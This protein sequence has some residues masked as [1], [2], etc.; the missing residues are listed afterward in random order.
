M[1][2]ENLISEY[3]PDE[4]GY[5]IV[6]KIVF[7]EGDLIQPGA[8]ILLVNTQIG[9]YWVVSHCRGIITTPLPLPSDRLGHDETVGFYVQVYIPL[10]DDETEFTFEK[11]LQDNHDLDE[12]AKT[13]RNKINTLWKDAD[14]LAQPEPSEEKPKTDKNTQQTSVMRPKPSLKRSLMHLII[15]ALFGAIV[16]LWMFEDINAPASN[17]WLTGAFFF[18]LVCTFLTSHRWIA[19]I[20]LALVFTAAFFYA[21]QYANFQSLQK[22]IASGSLN[23]LFQEE[24]GTDSSSDA[25]HLIHN[26]DNREMSRTELENAIETSGNEWDDEKGTDQYMVLSILVTN[27]T[28]ALLK[29]L[30]VDPFKTAQWRRLEFSPPLMP[31]EKRMSFIKVQRDDDG[32][33]LETKGRKE[34]DRWLRWS[35]T[36]RYVSVAPFNRK[37]HVA[38]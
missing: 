2:L 27:G 7:Q 11:A 28:N 34:E 16:G 15:M 3:I 22:A 31:H 13:E 35:N 29:S 26:W 25:D 6:E 21:P 5:M 38:K 8:R 17:A 18:G 9:K 1:I 33:P 20:S 10:S 12:I 24:I 30:K 36:H 37:N 4:F 32:Q 19:S 14:P 23:A